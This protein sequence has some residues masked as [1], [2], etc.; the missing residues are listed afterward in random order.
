MSVDRS[1]DV[2][3]D[4]NRVTISNLFDDDECRLAETDDGWRGFVRED[5]GEEPTYYWVDTFY[6]AEW[7][8]R[9]RV[10]Q[11]TVEAVVARWLADPDAI[12]GPRHRRRAPRHAPDGGDRGPP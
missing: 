8:G 11:A 3:L 7:P 10:S 12:H 2:D 1:V 5:D 6:G 9:I 4:A